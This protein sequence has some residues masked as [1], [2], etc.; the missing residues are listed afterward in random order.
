M[1]E[2]HAIFVVGKHLSSLRN[3]GEDLSSDPIRVGNSDVLPD[4][5]ADEYD[6]HYPPGPRRHK[7]VTDRVFEYSLVPSRDCRGEKVGLYIECDG[8]S[9]SVL[10]HAEI[11]PCNFSESIS[12]RVVTSRCNRYDVVRGV[13]N[14]FVIDKLHDKISISKLLFRIDGTTFCSENPIFGECR[15]GIYDSN[16]MTICS[17][18]FP[19]L[20]YDEFWER[21]DEYIVSRKEQIAELSRPNK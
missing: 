10:K 17:V 13:S 12:S 11:L 14:V 4:E 7:Q 19:F 20:P 8:S 1:D 9:I 2:E 15:I 6:K 3:S 16:S 5:L 18:S 21:L